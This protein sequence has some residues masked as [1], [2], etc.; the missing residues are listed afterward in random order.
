MFKKLLGLFIVYLMLILSIGVYGINVNDTP[1]VNDTDVETNIVNSTMN[2]T[3]NSTVNNSTVT[4]DPYADLGF[5]RFENHLCDFNEIPSGVGAWNHLRTEIMPNFNTDLNNLKDV[6]DYNANLADQLYDNC[7]LNYSSNS[8]GR[9]QHC[10]ISVAKDMYYYDCRYDSYS[11][12]ILSFL[13]EFAGIMVP[14]SISLSAATAVITSVLGVF[15]FAMGQSVTVA[16]VDDGAEAAVVST[17]GGN[18]MTYAKVFSITF[19]VI[20]ATGGLGTGVIAAVI[21]QD[22]AD[23]MRYWKYY[24]NYHGDIKLEVPY[25]S[26]KTSA[27]PVFPGGFN[28]TVDNS[29]NN[30]VNNSV[31]NESNISFN[32]SYRVFKPVTLSLGLGE[33]V[34]NNSSIVNN[35]TVDPVVNVNVDNSVYNGTDS[36]IDNGTNYVLDNQQSLPPTGVSNK[37]PHVDLPPKP[38]GFHVWDPVGDWGGFMSWNNPDF[39]PNCKKIDSKAYRPVKWYC[40]WNAIINLG[41]ALTVAVWWIGY[42][43][44]FTL[45]Y[46]AYIFYYLVLV[47]AGFVDMLITLPQ[48]LVYLNDITSQLP[49]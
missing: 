41:V 36:V 14:L 39:A 4:L 42:L 1:V 25:L 6:M 12:I 24:Q 22:K 16:T 38:L 45:T 19:G 40:P 11:G 30:T 10:P 2:S 23:L 35:S 47:V 13:D 49:K 29:V 46:I 37:K 31:V 17:V 48:L 44:L 21:A 26:S 32:S 33:P 34:I 20:G 15:I 27:T 5:K 9:F 7:T 43:L 3:V 8:G 18:G 28:S